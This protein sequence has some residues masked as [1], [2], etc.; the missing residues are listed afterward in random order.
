MNEISCRFSVW[1][2]N[3][4][5]VLFDTADTNEIKTFLN[6]ND[7]RLLQSVGNEIMIDN[8]KKKIARIHFSISPYDQFNHQTQIVVIVNQ[9]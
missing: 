9:D 5:I 7:L 8:V 4:E 3:S 6:N 1:E 2:E